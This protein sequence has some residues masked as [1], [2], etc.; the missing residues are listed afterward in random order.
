MLSRTFPR[1]GNSVRPRQK[2]FGEGWE[3]LKMARKSKVGRHRQ[4]AEIG[5]Y[6]ELGLENGIKLSFPQLF[7]PFPPIPTR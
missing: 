6:N 1:V 3:E 2:A 5:G 4:R 7:G